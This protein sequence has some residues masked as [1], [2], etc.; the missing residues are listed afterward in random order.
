MLKLKILV[1]A[2][3]SGFRKS[4][5]KCHYSPLNSHWN[6]TIHWALVT[7]ADETRSEEE[8]SKSKVFS[9]WSPFLYMVIKNGHNFAILA[10]ITFLNCHFTHHACSIKTVYKQITWDK[11][12][13]S[14]SFLC[15]DNIVQTED[16]NFITLCHVSS[17]L[18]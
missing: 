11:M 6:G 14:Y 18:H 5:H 2:I 12:A 15:G 16:I 17:Y 7:P 9:M 13:V 8:P 1:C 3:M 10:L 4:D